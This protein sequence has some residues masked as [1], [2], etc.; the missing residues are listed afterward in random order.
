MKLVLYILV[1]A[2]TGWVGWFCQPEIYNWMKGR[3]ETRKAAE[4]A[5][6]ASALNKTKQEADGTGGKNFNAAVLDA[7]INRNPAPPQTGGTGTSTSPGKTS[8]SASTAPSPDPAP[9]PVDEIE[10]RYPLPK[11]RTI[12]EITK[13]W[14]AIPS[15]AFPRKIKTK[16]DLNFDTPAGK[17]N[18]PTGSEARAAGM[19]AG[20]LIVMR[21][22]DENPR[23][24]VP[25]ANTDL[26]ETMTTLYEQYKEYRRN[27]VLKER[28]AARERKS[29]SN[30]ATEQEMALAGPRPDVRAGGVVPIMMDD[31]LT[32]KYTE[33]KAS[34]ITSWG[35]LAFEEVE[36]TK[37]WTG[38]LQVTVENPL[39][40][41][42]PT[43]VM[44]LIK[45]NKVVKWIYTGSREPVQ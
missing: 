12:E 11:F 18:L 5:K 22:E 26:K 21:L 31:I 45:D 7:L 33:L 9:A 20:M 8:A 29:K 3:L 35:N 41:P 13:E 44:A 1:I 19:V 14:S 42:Q 39:F 38:T 40:G 16:V 4:D 23:I 32:G 17:V 25:L 37:Y 15:R 24:Q 10:A 36:G 2:F 6:L 43:E 34:S 28:T 27:I 30:G